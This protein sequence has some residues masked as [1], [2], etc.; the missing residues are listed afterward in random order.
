M[1]KRLTNGS[2]FLRNSFILMGGTL[3]AQVLPLLLQPILR[4]IFSEEDFSDFELYFTLVSI[5]AVG[6]GLQY[7]T[8]VI[9]PEKDEDG[10]GILK[11]GL[12]ISLFFSCLV[13]VVLW[14]FGNTIFSWLEFPESMD[15]WM[16]FIPLSTF[17]ISAHLFFANWLTRKKAFKALVYNKIARRGSEGVF[18]FGLSKL[19]T[20]N[21]VILGTIIGDVVNFFMYL[22]QFRRTGGRFRS[23]HQS[24]VKQQLK[25]YKE[26]PIYSWLPYFLSTAALFIP[27][28][29][30]NNHYGSMDDT[31][32][33]HYGLSRMVLALPLAL[34]SMSLSQ[35]MIQRLAESRNEQQSV[36]TIYFKVG[37][38]LLGLAVVG[39]SICFFW[40]EPIFAT[41]F[42][43]KS[44]R[45]GAISE[46]LV[47][48]AAIRFVT[49]PLVTAFI[50]FERIKLNSI[51]QIFQFTATFSLYFFNNLDF[52]DFLWLY[53]GIELVL[54]ICYGLLAM[55]VIRSYE[56]S[57]R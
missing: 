25:R 42:G 49:A 52:N 4:R 54:Y 27:A 18:Q 34:I 56:K 14:C 1:I 19:W 48:S 50:A 31:L 8:A 10:L 7:H 11:G 35:V 38:G 51:W 36:K 37:A 22:F 41:I 28:L 30:I 5:L 17:L 29:I 12:Q 53:V 26:F 46:I 15:R 2:E 3:V 57:I 20:G 13:F 21:G 39:V 55:N 9:L 24:K 45:A 23:V 6:S 47:F 33:G 43:E 32:V 44:A 40:G 16:Y